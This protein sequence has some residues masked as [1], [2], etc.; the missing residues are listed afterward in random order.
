ME[1]VV[2]ADD[3]ALP[4]DKGITGRRGVAGTV[5]V[6]KIAG[7]A[8]AAGLSLEAVR[9]A[10]VEATQQIGTLGVALGGCTLPGEACYV[11]L[12]ALTVHMGQE[13]PPTTGL[14]AT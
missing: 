14:M 3:C 1:L 12:A 6:H 9:D 7:A 8:A 5:L 10:A 11:C 2:V 13:K 4:K